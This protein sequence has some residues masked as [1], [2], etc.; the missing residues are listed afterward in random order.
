MAHVTVL[1][2]KYFTFRKIWNKQWTEENKNPSKET[3]IVDKFN[4]IFNLPLQFS[5][6]LK[7]L[8][9]MITVKSGLL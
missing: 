2:H 6:H 9:N 8:E 5:I 1:S 3:K 7:L 4:D